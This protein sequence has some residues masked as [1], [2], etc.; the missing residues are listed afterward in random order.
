MVYFLLGLLLL[1]LVFFLARGMSNASPAQ[2]ANVVRYVGGGLA[3]LVSAFLFARGGGVLAA[4]LA[5]FGLWL[6][7]GAPGSGTVFQP[8]STGQV[9]E[10]STDYLHMEL[11][12]DTGDI[13][14]TV[15]KGLFVGHRIEHLKPEDLVLLWQDCRSEDPQ[16]AQIIEA[17]LDRTFPTWRD[18]VKRGEEKMSGGPDGRMSIDEAL[19]ILGLRL[20]CSADD[21]RRA[22]R[23]LMLKLH[24][25]H[26]GSNYLAT[27]INEAKDVLLSELE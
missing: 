5:M 10:V 8:K 1:I 27:K 20:G 16:S 4:P 26:G 7:G 14:G 3:L 22:H 15:R 19:E 9:S 23:E 12:H 2:V 6:M 17:Y 11:D 24:P 21:V 13:R 25:D 18:D